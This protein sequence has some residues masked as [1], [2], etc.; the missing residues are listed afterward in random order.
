MLYVW[1]RVMYKI[2]QALIG[3][4]I[5]QSLTLGNL[6]ENAL[7]ERREFFI[8][9]LMF[10]I[11]AFD[12]SLT[13]LCNFTF[14]SRRGKCCRSCIKQNIHNMIHLH[15]KVWAHYTN[16]LIARLTNYPVIQ[17]L[18]VSQ[19]QVVKENW[20][21]DMGD[22]QHTTWKVFYNIFHVSVTDRG[23]RN[24]SGHKA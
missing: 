18:K 20:R 9:I 22:L 3:M 5:L 4:A 11:G 13:S 2:M 10:N 12:C 24:F 8:C 17:V 1:Q 14:T 19:I 6:G 16:E 21:K 15:L 23:V 7:D